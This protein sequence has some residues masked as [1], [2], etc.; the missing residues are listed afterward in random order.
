LTGTLVLTML[1][2]HVSHAVR[3]TAAASLPKA[4]R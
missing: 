4:V 3:R 1:R 2:E